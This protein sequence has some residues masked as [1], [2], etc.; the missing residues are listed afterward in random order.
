MLK[1]LKHLKV[2]CKQLDP[3][4]TANEC[5]SIYNIIL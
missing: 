2:H 3:I 1:S 4:G 5:T